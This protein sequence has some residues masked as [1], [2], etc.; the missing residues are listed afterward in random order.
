MWRCDALM[1]R[2]P[3]KPI[4]LAQTSLPIAQDGGTDWHQTVA[5]E[6]GTI[7]V[8]APIDT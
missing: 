1:P 6:R 3:S 4:V 5:P 2:P 8:M 7:L